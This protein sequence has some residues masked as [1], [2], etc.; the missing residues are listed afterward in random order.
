MATIVQNLDQQKIFFL[1]EIFYHWHYLDL[2]AHSDNKKY[3][4]LIHFIIII[5]VFTG[6]SLPYTTPHHPIL[7]CQAA[8]ITFPP[9]QL[10]TYRFSLVNILKHPYSIILTQLPVKNQTAGKIGSIVNSQLP[11][12][13][14]LIHTGY[15][16]LL[17]QDYLKPSLLF[18]PSCF[19]FH[20]W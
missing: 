3:Q 20:S 5:K 9:Q 14:G 19:P 4:F 18:P 12:S 16:V 10:H 15:L 13:V 17:P 6:N 2:L 8:V 7:S 1:G 11:I